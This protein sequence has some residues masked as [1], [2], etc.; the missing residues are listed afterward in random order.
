[1]VLSALY[2]L[3]RL[4]FANGLSAAN[5]LSI[6]ERAT[7]NRREASDFSRQFQQN[8][9]CVFVNLVNVP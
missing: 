2:S 7:E 1:M 3:S 6:V 8:L 9:K 4:I 5:H